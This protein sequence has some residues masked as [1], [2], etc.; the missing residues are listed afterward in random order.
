MTFP[1]LLHEKLAGV[2]ENLGV[3]G[4]LGQSVEPHSDRLICVS[5]PDVELSQSVSQSAGLR[6]ELQQR[7]AEDDTFIKPVERRQ[8]PGQH[9]YMTSSH[10]E[11]SDCLWVQQ[12]FTYRHTVL[13]YQQHSKQWLRE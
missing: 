3:I 8:T 7:L 11:H 12:S 6:T 5:S 9:C 1:H 13:V 10:P 4:T 2:I